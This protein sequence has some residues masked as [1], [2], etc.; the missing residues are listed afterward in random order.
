MAQLIITV[1]NEI[2][3]IMYKYQP[4]PIDISGSCLCLYL[5]SL[6]IDFIVIMLHTQ[7]NNEAGGNATLNRDMYPNYI[8]RSL[9]ASAVEFSSHSI[10]LLLNIIWYSIFT[11]CECITSYFTSFHSFSSFETL[12]LNQIA[13]LKYLVKVSLS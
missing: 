2:N 6:I 11:F 10:R 12:Y 3:S 8:T 1:T 7:Q 13:V 9:K 4:M 5:N